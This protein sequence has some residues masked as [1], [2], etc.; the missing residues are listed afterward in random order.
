MVVATTPDEL[1]AAR[2]LFVEYAESL[3]WDLSSGGRFAEEVADPPGPYAPPGGALLLAYVDGVP[4]GVLGL[5]RVPCDAQVTGIG[6]EHLGELKRLYVRP[7][8]RR[9]GVA[10]ALMLRAEQEARYWGYRQVVLTT[11]DRPFPLAKGLYDSL[12]Y[13]QIEPYRTDLTWP[14]LVWLGKDL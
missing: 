12:G 6:A 2:A 13:R 5:Q 4:A 11:A 14:D 9:A 3:G 10:R 7:A 8:H 1:E